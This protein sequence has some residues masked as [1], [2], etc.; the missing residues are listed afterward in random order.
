MAE[1]GK[2]EPTEVPSIEP[3]RLHGLQKPGVSVLDPS[4]GIRTIKLVSPICDICAP[5]QWNVSPN[6]V[7]E[8]PHSPYTHY[9]FQ[10]EVKTEFEDRPDGSRVVKSR[11]IESVERPWPNLRQVPASPR[12]TGN[13]LVGNAAEMARQKYVQ[14]GWVPPED[15]RCEAFPNGL[16]AMC[17]YRDCFAQDIKQYASGWFC[18]EE[19]AIICWEDQNYVKTE[20]YN[21]L[22]RHEQ[23]ADSTSRLRALS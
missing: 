21:E 17:Q 13:N 2:P 23:F 1:N 20:V 8:C 19:E 15:V 9:E 11:E 12:H 6:W 7:I 16:A 18:R 3:L 5:E 14:F 22:E 10:D 4:R